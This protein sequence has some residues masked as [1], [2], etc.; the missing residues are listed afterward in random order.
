MKSVLGRREGGY[1]LSAEEE[2]NMVEEPKIMDISRVA[3]GK[4][5]DIL[6]DVGFKIVFWKGGKQEH[7]YRV[8]EPCNNR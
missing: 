1:Q 5:V 2:A 3:I 4:Y 6:S 7:N 8:S